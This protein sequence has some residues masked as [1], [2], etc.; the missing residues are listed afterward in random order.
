VAARRALR[1]LADGVPPP[2]D[3]A[4]WLTVGQSAVLAEFESDLEAIA[5]GDFRSLLVLGGSGSG[6]SQ[7]LLSMRRLAADR[8]FLTAYVA[9]DPASR[10][11]FN[12]PDRIYRRLVETL[13]LPNDP[14]GSADPL[15]MVMDRWADEALPRLVGTS[16]SGAIAFRLS[17]AG[18]LPRE[19]RGIPPRTR[20]ALVGFLIATEQRSEDA[21]REFLN[22]L[23]GVGLTN[24]ELVH[25]ARGLGYE[26]G[27]VG[28]TPTAYD[29][30]YHFGQLRVLLFVAR[31]LGYPGMVVLFDEA[32]T[33]VELAARSRDKACRVLDGLLFNEYQFQGLYPVFAY[34]P[35]LFDRLD[36]DQERLGIDL[37]ARWRE[38]WRERTREIAPLSAAQMLE[39]VEQ[40][41]HL[42]GIARGWVAWP[43]IAADRRHLIA[44]CLARRL[45]TRDLVRKGVAMLERRYA[46]SGPTAQH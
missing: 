32:V 3:P 33:L 46:E 41:A 12:R 25:L 28:W 39:L 21:C 11:G 34:M 27:Y 4:R 31:A 23:R 1:A 26:P 37:V 19:T 8:G 38:L 5:G 35:A 29:A 43:R 15:R 22:V 24:T 2:G 42:H 7:L 17:A 14:G 16:R 13:S 36:A 10:V 18:L 20:L 44:L 45:P 9:H 30:R 40:L 6:K